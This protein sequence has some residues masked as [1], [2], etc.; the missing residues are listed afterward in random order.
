LRQDALS[1]QQNDGISDPTVLQT[2]AV[3]AIR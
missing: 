3:C 1:L 2:R